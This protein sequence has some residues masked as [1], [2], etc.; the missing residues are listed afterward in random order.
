MSMLAAQNAAA[1]RLGGSTMWRDAMM[2]EMPD[3]WAV[4]DADLVAAVRQPT[5]PAAPV[6]PSP[7]DLERQEYMG[8]LKAGQIDENGMAKNGKMYRGPK[9]REFAALHG[10]WEPVLKDKDLAQQLNRI[11]MN[12]NRAFAGLEALPE[13]VVQGPKI[14][15]SDEE[16]AAV[17]QH[18]ALTGQYPDGRK[19]PS[20]IVQIA[21]AQV[22][23]EGSKRAADMEKAQRAREKARQAKLKAMQLDFQF[24]PAAFD[25]LKQSERI[26]NEKGLLAAGRAAGW[27]PRGL[28][29]DREDLKN[30]LNSIGAEE[31]KKNVEAL[32]S[33]SENGT[34]GMRLTQ[35]EIMK[36]IQRAGPLTVDTSPETLLRTVRNLRNR[37]SH[38]VGLAARQLRQFDP[39]AYAEM[40]EWLQQGDPEIYQL[41]LDAAKDAAQTPATAPAADVRG[42]SNEELLRQL[43]GM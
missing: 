38:E 28:D 10:G 37:L 7:A 43:G 35:E 36:E 16:R 29:Q 26:L 21:G 34:L 14:P 13:A 40:G 19:A 22:F 17:L 11:T 5:A 20:E 12:E 8:L 2:P 31:L 1:E 23:P 15:E 24:L 4:P 18:V 33:T 42:L 9:A 25:A 3:F 39:Q 6:Q 32:R 41:Y 30:Y 27:L